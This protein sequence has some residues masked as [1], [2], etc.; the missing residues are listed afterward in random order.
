MGTSCHP[1]LRINEERRYNMIQ[2]LLRKGIRSFILED[3]RVLYRSSLRHLMNR[4]SAGRRSL[5]R[6][7]ASL[8]VGPIS[9]QYSLRRQW[10]RAVLGTLYELTAH[11]SVTRPH[12]ARRI[13]SK[14]CYFYAHGGVARWPSG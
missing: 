10:M 11:Y 12:R 6:C 4:E 2:L 14:L 13:M 5:Q 3:L 1:C 8:S 7:G 9:P